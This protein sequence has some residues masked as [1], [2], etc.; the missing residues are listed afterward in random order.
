MQS[1]NQSSRQVRICL[2]V[3]GFPTCCSSQLLLLW[4]EATAAGLAPEQGSQG[5]CPKV[6]DGCCVFLLQMSSQ[7]NFK[8]LVI[9]NAFLQLV[10]SCRLRCCLWFILSF[11]YP[12]VINAFPL[13]AGC[14]HHRATSS[15]RFMFPCVFRTPGAQLGAKEVSI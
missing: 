6:F 5:R 2:R 14:V 7:S 3:A 13:I 12:N 10:Q 11:L 4:C 1:P 15:G 8:V 9:Q